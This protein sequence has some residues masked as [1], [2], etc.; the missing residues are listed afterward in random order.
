VVIADGELTALLFGDGARTVVHLPDGGEERE[1][2][3]RLS[4]FAIASW[5]RRRALRIIGHESE[6]PMN[7]S[8]LT[9]ALGQA[10]LIPSGRG[11]RI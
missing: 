7:A 9:A 2:L 3:G 5:M 4:A 6:A 10:G 8:V 1:G 11:F